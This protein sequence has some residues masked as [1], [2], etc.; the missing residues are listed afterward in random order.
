MTNK[1][2]DKNISFEFLLAAPIDVVYKVWTTK[3]GLESFFAP[4]CKIDLKLFG[5]L[6]IHFFPDNKPGQ[7]GAED[8]KIIS[9]EE[10]K[11]LSFTWGFPPSIMNLR[12]NQ[13]TIVL[14][15]FKDTGFGQTIV[16]FIQS[17]WGDSDEWRLGYEYFYEAWGDVVLARLQY[18]FEHGVIDWNNLPD[19][20]SYSLIK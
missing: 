9:F 3:E 20:S 19:F 18:I 5:D 11:M 17:G 10:N 15:R 13:K 7:K 6:H 2:D 12:N 16:T 1:S 4:E 8:E 14:L